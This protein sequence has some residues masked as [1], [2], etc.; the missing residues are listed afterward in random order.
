MPAGGGSRRRGLARLSSPILSHRPAGTFPPLAKTRGILGRTGQ[1]PIASDSK[2]R[3]EFGVLLPPSPVETLFWNRLSVALTEIDRHLLQRCLAEEPGAWKDFVDRFLGLFVHVIQHTGHARS[4]PITTDDIDDLCSEVF[5][6]L[7]AND[8]AV[9]RQ[10]R[11]ESSLATYITVVSRRVVVREMARR[12]MSEALGHVNVG[13]SALEH[14][15]VTRS[16]MQRVENQD[17]VQRMLAG[18]PEREAAVVRQYHLE[19]RT[20]R[21]ISTGLGISENTV[22]PMLSRAA[23][24]LRERGE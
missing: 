8:Y 23:A 14:A 4:V 10:F 6:A 19:G 5:L 16:D 18:L 15:H 22:G 24:K 3:V 17:Q 12:R 20:Y 9:L 11:G 2:S 21:E 13:A 1:T 7:L